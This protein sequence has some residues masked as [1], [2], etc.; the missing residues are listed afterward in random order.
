LGMNCP[1]MDALKVN[2]KQKSPETSTLCHIYIYLHP[3]IL[4]QI[5]E[6]H[7]Y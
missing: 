2:K 5:R 4:L 3:E 1:D 6:K 7:P